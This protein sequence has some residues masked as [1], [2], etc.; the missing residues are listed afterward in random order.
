MLA[1]FWVGNLWLAWLN[2]SIGRIAGGCH[3]RP[4]GNLRFGL[5]ATAVAT[6]SG[7]LRSACRSAPVSLRSSYLNLPES[8]RSAGGR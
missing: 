7:N 2:S 8:T 1:V 5:L 4:S 3:R 6:L